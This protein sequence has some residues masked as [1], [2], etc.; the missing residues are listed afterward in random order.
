MKEYSATTTTIDAVL[1]SFFEDNADI[2][3][4]SWPEGDHISSDG[5]EGGTIWYYCEAE[6]E[7]TPDYRLGFNELIAG[8]WQI[9]ILERK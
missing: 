3:R 5:A 1:Q 8:D 2:R 6:D 4:A 9:E 7:L